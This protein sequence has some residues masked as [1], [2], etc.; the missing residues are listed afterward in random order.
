ML[1]S[2]GF[3]FIVLADNL[4]RKLLFYCGTQRENSCFIPLRP[5]LHYFGIYRIIWLTHYRGLRIRLLI[6]S[7][8]NNSWHGIGTHGIY[9]EFQD[10]S[11][12]MGFG[13]QNLKL[14]ELGEFE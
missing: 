2:S 1:K 6:F 10:E 8:Q 3:S 7:K 9:A 14:T 4:D 13:A 11:I 5:E 12:E